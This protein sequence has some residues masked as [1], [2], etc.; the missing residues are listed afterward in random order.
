MSLPT[1][2]KERVKSGNIYAYVDQQLGKEQ[3]AYE[4]NCLNELGARQT[5]TIR[6]LLSLPSQEVSMIYI[7]SHGT[8]MR[9]DNEDI[10]FAS[11]RTKDDILLR[12]HELARYKKW[13]PAQRPVFF[14]NACHSARIWKEGEIQGFPDLILSRFGSGYIGTLGYVNNS[15][16]S[17]I[18]ESILS[19][20][21][22]TE[23][24]HQTIPSI[25]RQLRDEAAQNVSVN[26]PKEVL[27][28]FLDSFMYVYYG[29][30]LLLCDLTS[31]KK[32]K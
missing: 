5:N 27:S 15:N 31:D 23:E 8:F 20:V 19:R 4:S 16:A 6:E 24:N 26:S 12:I 17:K 13:D 29:N 10:I 3:I 28:Y 1:E 32:S 25:L 18:A 7:A 30:P 21:Y 9:D 14:V 2:I 22:T 11:L